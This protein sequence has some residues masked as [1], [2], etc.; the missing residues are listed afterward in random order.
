MVG[1]RNCLICRRRRID[2]NTIMG[3]TVEFY[4]VE[5]EHFDEVLKTGDGDR[6]ME[7]LEKCPV[8]DFSFHIEIPYDLDG[9]C[10]QLR[11][12]GAQVSPFIRNALV[13]QLF[14]D[15]P[16]ESLALLTND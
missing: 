16:V 10:G 9:L 6:I 12:Q 5:P 13:E 8:V 11:E 7:A 14:D 2:R 15:G 3:T 4:A 1:T